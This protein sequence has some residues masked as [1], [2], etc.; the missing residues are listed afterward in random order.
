MIL[1][2]CILISP[3]NSGSTMRFWWI[4]KAGPERSR[5]NGSR[6]LPH[7]VEVDAVSAQFREI[8]GHHA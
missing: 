2:I 3:L 6:S 4:L 7:Q 5:F 8:P 1:R